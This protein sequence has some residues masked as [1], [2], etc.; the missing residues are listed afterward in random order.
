MAA[1]KT[2]QVPHLYYQDISVA[3]NA[4][5]G[6]VLPYY[7]NNNTTI[8]GYKLISATLIG[9]STTS[10]FVTIRGEEYGGGIYI[11]TEREGPH[12]VRC[13]YMKE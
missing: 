2:I 7:G 12:K 10:G 9:T 13:V 1:S 4:Q 11:W 5:A 6:G 3:V 8:S